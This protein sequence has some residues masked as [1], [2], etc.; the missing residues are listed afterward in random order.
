V[1]ELEVQLANS[2]NA[3]PAGSP[4]KA[5]AEAKHSDDSTAED[6]QA[7]GGVKHTRGSVVMRAM[8]EFSQNMDDQDQHDDGDE[9]SDEYT[10]EEE[11]EEQQAQQGGAADDAK[12][13]AAGP[14]KPLAVEVP[15]MLKKIQAGIAKM[16][17]DLRG[18]S[19]VVLVSCG[20]YNP[21]HLMHLRAFYIA[22]Q[23]FET[24][25]NYQVVGGIMSPSHDTIVRGKVRRTP[26]QLITCRHRLGLCQAAVHDSSWISI[27]RWEI[28]R[29]RLMDY[30]SVLK[31]L[32]NLMNRYFP[33]VAIRLVYLCGGN[34]LLQL[35]P[36]AM[37]EEGYGCIAICRPGQTDELLKQIPTA[38]TGLAHLVEDTAV[39]SRDLEGSSSV[40]IRQ[41]MIDR[42]DIRAKVGMRVAKVCAHYKLG[43]KIGGRA[44]WTDEDKKWRPEDK[45]YQDATINEGMGD[46][47]RRRDNNSRDDGGR[48]R[49]AGRIDAAEA[50]G[51]DR[52]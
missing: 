50:K 13:V 15:D 37:K 48:R 46:E 47:D 21:I 42:K 6:E 9:Y 28:T 31:H 19:F 45:A 35:S 5:A 25:T 20:C 41:D 16:G 27:D 40:R 3:S 44:N 4:S 34:H 2:P 22:R 49:S 39:I 29:R 52:R 32:Q 12:T 24:H 43:D 1:S 30:L 8:D 17:P 23:F 26:K 18:K 14:E 33:E 11:E 51:V 36:K 10:D 7:Y 38:W